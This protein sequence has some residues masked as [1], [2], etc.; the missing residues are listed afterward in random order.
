MRPLSVVGSRVLYGLR[1]ICRVDILFS[2]TVLIDLGTAYRETKVVHPPSS[3]II[4]IIITII[5][6]IIIIISTVI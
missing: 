3:A 1:V 6:I 4:I 5:I 2:N